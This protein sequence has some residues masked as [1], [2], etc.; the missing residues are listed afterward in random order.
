L[1]GEQIE[2]GSGSAAI[3]TRSGALLDRLAREVRSCPGV[4]RIDGHTDPVGRGRFNRGLSEARAAAVRDALVARGVP[5]ERLRTRGFAER[6]AARPEVDLRPLTEELTALSEQLTALD[7]SM[8]PN[9]AAVEKRLTAIEHALFPVQT[10]L[11]ELEGAVRAFS[12][13][14]VLERLG[15]L[16]S[17][18]E[19]QPNPEVVVS[20]GQVGH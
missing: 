5:A 17:R 8:R 1:A 2:F 13:T 16:A 7:D 6:L 15:T 3:G 9:L 10:R 14:P 20:E 11:D 19:N 4:I 18:L 12:L